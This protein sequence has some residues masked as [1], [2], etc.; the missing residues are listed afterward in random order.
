MEE[1]M[2]RLVIQDDIAD[3]L[4]NRGGIYGPIVT[5]AEACESQN[6]ER[7][8]DLA[9]SLMLSPEQVTKDHLQALAW[10]EQIGLD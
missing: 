4:L 8:E 6:P 3:A 2:D 10:V 1:I 7:I 9:M 5:L